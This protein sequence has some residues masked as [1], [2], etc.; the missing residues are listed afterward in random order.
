MTLDV[1]NVEF[2]IQGTGTV[3]ETPTITA[4]ANAASFLPTESFDVTWTSTSDPTGF[5]IIAEGATTEFFEVA[6]GGAARTHTI[7]SGQLAEGAWTIRVRAANLGTFIG[8]TES[9]SEMEIG[10]EA[11]SPPTITVAP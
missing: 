1:S 8:D 11:A 9:A 3:P 10:A 6:G 4:P 7:L 5:V 2:V